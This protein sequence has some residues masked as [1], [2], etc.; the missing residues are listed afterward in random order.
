[1]QTFALA[2]KYRKNYSFEAK[3]EIKLDE[4][5]VFCLS[6]QNMS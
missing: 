1:M 6:K 4:V 5:F 2:C 3:R